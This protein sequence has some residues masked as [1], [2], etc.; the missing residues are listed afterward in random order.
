[1]TEKRYAMA[2]D[3][4]KC[5]GCSTCVIACK[6]ENNVS[7]HHYRDWIEQETHR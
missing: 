1:M 6:E 4:K 7:L 5:V 2:V 3:M